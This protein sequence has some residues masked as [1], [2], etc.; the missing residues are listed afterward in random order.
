MYFSMHRSIA[1]YNDLRLI[2]ILHVTVVDSFLLLNGILQYLPIHVLMVI[3]FV[4]LPILAIIDIPLLN[5][6]GSLSCRHFF[7]SLGQID[8]R[9]AGSNIKCV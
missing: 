3:C 1:Q 9:I 8:R 6:H 2:D 5:S 4:F 7:L